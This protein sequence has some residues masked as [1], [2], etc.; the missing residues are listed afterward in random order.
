[1][2]LFTG[3]SW[4]QYL[5]SDNPQVGFNQNQIKQ[6]QKIKPG[7]KIIAYL[8]KV[9]GFVGILEASDF[10]I[11][12]EEE[13]W[14]EGLFPVRVKAK[15]TIKVPIPRSTNSIS[16]WRV[17]FSKDGQLKSP[18]AWSVHVRSSPRKWKSED[19]LLIEERLHQQF[20]IHLLRI[21][22]V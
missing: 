21:M 17:K 19:G 20:E 10:A 13:K 16:S 5:S 9:G 6:A 14:S 18:H 11:V 1:M 3:T 4:D 15:P 8:T 12:S 2:S 22:T 7:D